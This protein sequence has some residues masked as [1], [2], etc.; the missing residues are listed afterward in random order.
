MTQY[1]IRRLITSIPS[2]ILVTVI[3]FSLI[4]IVPGDVVIARLGES[5]YVTD[6]QLQE[7]R[8][9]LGL[10]KPAYQQYFS[11]ASGVVRGDFGKSLWTSENVLPKIAAR[12][13]V[14]LQIAIMAITIAVIIAIPMGILSAVKRNTWIDYASRLFAII[15]LSLPDFWIATMLLLVLTLYIGWLPEFGYYPIWQHPIKN[16]EALMFPVMIIG[17]RFSASSSRMM[18]SAML[19]VLREDYIRTARSKGLS[20]RAIVIRHALKNSLIPVITI[21]GGLL[22]F[23]LGGLVVIET[24]FA[25]PGMGRTA[26]D[27]VT[28]R[29]YPVIQGVV[30]VMAIVFVFAN[31]IVDLS[32]A[33]ID[34]RIR[35]S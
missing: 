3:I 2:L 16:L 28:V 34:P 19:E 7:M 8:H 12:M 6:Q 29:D 5:G 33:V 10:D 13:R 26:F 24:I 21:L 14:S 31:L 4:R 23:M 1:I 18:R 35:Y 32:Y 27:A 11:W 22:S 30:L 15:G 17:Y 20:E 9:D 25:L